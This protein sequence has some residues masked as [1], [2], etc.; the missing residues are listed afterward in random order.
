M[1]IYHLL[2]VTPL[3]K[4]LGRLV[5]FESQIFPL[6]LFETSLNIFLVDVIQFGLNPLRFFHALKALRIAVNNVE[7]MFDFGHPKI[8]VSR[9]TC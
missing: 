9:M 4:S 5:N 3:K 1:E 7:T 6:L 8:D 2:V